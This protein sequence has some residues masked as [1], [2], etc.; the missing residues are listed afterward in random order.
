MQALGKQA[1][2]GAGWRGL[3]VFGSKDPMF[4]SEVINESSDS[5]GR[6]GYEAVR[7]NCLEAETYG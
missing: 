4:L 1:G 6:I 5:G 3:F 2:S 7:G